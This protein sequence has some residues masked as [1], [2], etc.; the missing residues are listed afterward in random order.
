VA[1]HTALPVRSDGH[2]ARLST[3]PSPP[4]RADMAT[5]QA[6]KAKTIPVSFSLPAEIDAEE[7]ALCGE[8]NDWSPD[9]QLTQNGDGSWHTIINLPPDAYR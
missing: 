2:T 4:E 9:T 5:R 7:V 6:T 8:F 1:P 3:T